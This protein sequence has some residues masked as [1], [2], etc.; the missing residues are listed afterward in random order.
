MFFEEIW[1]FNFVGV[2]FFGGLYLVY[3]DEF[4]IFFEGFFVFIWEQGIVL[5]G[6]CNVLYLIVDLLGGKVNYV[7]YYEYGC[8][9]IF[10]VEKSCF[11]GD[12]EVMYNWMVWMGYGD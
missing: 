7:E 9:Q 12:F 6:I 8:M 5:L 1:E 3:F 10:V 2:I 11:Y 4:L